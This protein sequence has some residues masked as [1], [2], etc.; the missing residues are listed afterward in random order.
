MTGQTDS[1]AQEI[2]RRARK[3]RRKRENRSL[4]A[5]ALLAVVLITGIT[6]ILAGSGGGMASAD[7]G[8]GSLVLRSGAGLYVVVGVTAFTAGM[9]L[10]LVC[11]RLSDA[12]KARKKKTIAAETSADAQ[13]KGKS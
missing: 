8:Y 7:G 3:Y 13:G 10:T 6:A 1:R 9:A 2:K 12:G 11:V 5:L 4:G